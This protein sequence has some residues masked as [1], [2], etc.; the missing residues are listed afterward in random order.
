MF[1][2]LNVALIEQLITPDHCQRSGQERQKSMKM[3]RISWQAQLAE[4]DQH[5]SPQPQQGVT[6]FCQIILSVEM[7]DR[8]ICE[9]QACKRT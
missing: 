7:A 5:L 4:R 8:F 2:I 6:L 1:W 9:W 3:Q